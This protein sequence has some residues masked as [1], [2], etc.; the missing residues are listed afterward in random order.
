LCAGGRST[1]H[2]QLRHDT[3]CPREVNAAM[4]RRRGAIVDMASVHTTN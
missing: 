2:G 3:S 4:R 1:L